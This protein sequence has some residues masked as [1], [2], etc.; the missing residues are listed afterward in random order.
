[1]HHPCQIARP[2]WSTVSDYDPD[3]ARQSRQRMLSS[4]AGTDTLVLG[5]HFPPPT[6]GRVL[7][8]HGGFEL[9]P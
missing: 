6:A 1:M 3:L 8:V 5:S 9:R 7:S 2:A 4:V